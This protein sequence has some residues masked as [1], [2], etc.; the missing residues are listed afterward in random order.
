MELFSAIL[1]AQHMQLT[2]KQ[3]QE[4]ARDPAVPSPSHTLEKQTQ[5]R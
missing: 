5:R 4:P 1:C 2:G 3:Q